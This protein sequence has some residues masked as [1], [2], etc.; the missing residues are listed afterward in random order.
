LNILDG[1]LSPTWSTDITIDGD[2]DIRYLLS[3]S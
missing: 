3:I 1:P 2:I